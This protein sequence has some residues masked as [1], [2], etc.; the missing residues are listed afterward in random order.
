MWPV[1]NPLAI[2][3]HYWQSEIENRNPIVK[4]ILDEN[5]RLIVI[6]VTS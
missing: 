4:E 1:E 2:V 6:L 5:E 3:C